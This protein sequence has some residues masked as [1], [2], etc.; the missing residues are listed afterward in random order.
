MKNN[1]TSQT[2]N[3]HLLDTFPLQH[4][5]DAMI[6]AWKFSH[7]DVD[8]DRLVHYNE[9]FVSHMKK[10]FGRIKR[11]RKCSKR[12]FVTCDADH[13]NGLS[14][15]EWRSCLQ[16]RR[17]RSMSGKLG[18]SYGKTFQVVFVFVFALRFHIS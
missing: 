7:L 6:M 5:P 12:L 4:L 18:H 15:V 17:P 3:L 9:L 10:V 16:R 1:L 8:T 11:G 2:G 13:N 14:L